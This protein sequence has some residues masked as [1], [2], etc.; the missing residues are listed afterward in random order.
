MQRQADKPAL[1]MSA[2]DDELRSLSD[3]IGETR[4]RL[5]VPDTAIFGGS[6]FT[7]RK[8]QLQLK[9]GL[10]TVQEGVEFFSLGLRMLGSDVGY[11][12]QLFGRASLGNTLKPRE[13]S[14]R[15]SACAVCKLFAAAGPLTVCTL[16]LY[17]LTLQALRCTLRDLFTFVPFTCASLPV[18]YTH[19]TLPTKR[20]V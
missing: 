11:S 4:L 12:G 8:L 16:H 20:I 10:S 18:S 1:L 14:V 15:S 7:L 3:E 5:G 9:E 17:L 13:V 6:G 19:L 2:F